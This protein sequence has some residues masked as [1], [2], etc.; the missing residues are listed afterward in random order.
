MNKNSILDKITKNILEIVYSKERKIE[1]YLFLLLALGFVLRFIATINLSVL[2]DDMLYASQ[3]AG[4]WSAKILSTHS[5]PPLF[6][7]LTDLS[8]KVFGYTTF[9]SRFFPLIAGTFSILLVFL[10][11]EKLFDHKKKA[12]ASAFLA[13]F[14][15]FL[16]R[17]T[18]T[19]MSHVWLFFVFLGVYFGMSF[20]ETKKQI[21]L[22][23]S[24]ISFGIGILTKYNAPFYILAFLIYS[25]FYLRIN[26]VKI[27][28]KE[29]AVSLGTFLIILLLFSL[30]F[31][32]FNYLIYK[33]KGI[34]DVYFSRVIQ[35]EATQQLYGSLA[36]QGS[37]FT[38]NLFNLENYNLY[39]IVFYTDIAMFLFA[40]FATVLLYK[41][42]KSIPII[43]FGLFLLIP[44]ILQ[45]AGSNLGKHFVFMPF[46]FSI[47]GG[48]GL[49]FTLNKLGNRK[50]KIIFLFFLTFFLIYSIGNSFHTPQYFL[51][52]SPTSQ[53][54]VY[55][56]ENV[57]ENDLIVF[58]PR[59]YTARS[60]WIATPHHQ[61]N[62]IDFVEFSN[63]HL[64]LPQEIKTPVNVYFVEC[65]IDDCGWGTIK[66]QPELNNTVEFI[67]GQL[68]SD[69][70]PAKTIYGKEFVGNEILSKKN[71]FIEYKIYKKQFMLNYISV[72]QL[73]KAN[74]FYFT[75]Y[76][77][78]EKSQYIFN[79]EIKSLQDRLLNSFSYFM[80]LLAV[81]LSIL[82]FFIL[83][84]YVFF[85]KAQNKNQLSVQDQSKN[86]LLENNQYL[87]EV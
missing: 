59:I 87:S 26:N 6:F 36:G 22:I 64:E 42:K 55:I 85:K 13:T 38:D 61:I 25:I 43:F 20:L 17:N 67:I 72:S 40:L 58:D 45:S 24:S 23:L 74:S 19:E 53:L 12:L 84:I 7:Y 48:Y 75:P 80:I 15:T 30:P 73:D 5:N 47:I 56:N 18:F 71:E 27:L 1:R 4:I 10:I 37:S 57:N 54:K 9:A 70:S 41:N 63:Q 33:D 49:Y 79:Y 3:S 68:I 86:Q 14:S 46:L 82:S 39:S 32:S 76:L 44:F 35:T 62:L 78:K 83:F 77:Y 51:E 52:P 16:I 29:N 8:Y 11:A 60:F 34:L 28:T 81:I 69:S 50:L 31:L 65:Y 2:A 21:F 66:N